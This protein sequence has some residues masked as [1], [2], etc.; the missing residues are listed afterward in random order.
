LL[1]NRALRILLITNTLVL[2][3]GGM[4]GPIYALFVEDIGGRLLDA[5]IAIAI[6]AAV[7]GITTIVAGK[8]T[9]RA[10]RKEFIVGI[11]YALMGISF[12]LYIFADSVY[13][14]FGIVI[15]TGFAEALYA[16]AF[17]SLFSQHTTKR[18]VG[19]EWGTWEATDYFAGAFGA[20]T[21]G[22]LVTLF[23]FNVLFM[24]MAALCFISAIYIYFLPRRVL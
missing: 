10:K 11:G 14:I 19:L 2:I 3:A 9:D 6:F 20:I 24:A 23:G 4:L 12:L 22:A 13:F 7:A 21:G 18:K 17:D 16:P 8:H 5:S 15:L 1:F